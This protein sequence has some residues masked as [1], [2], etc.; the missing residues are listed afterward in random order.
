M[1]QCQIDI[2]IGSGLEVG[3]LASVCNNSLGVIKLKM[4]CCF[5]RHNSNAYLIFQPCVMTV[6]KRKW[7][8]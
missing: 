1:Y 5:V 6:L 7:H 8:E 3:G 4:A 2:D